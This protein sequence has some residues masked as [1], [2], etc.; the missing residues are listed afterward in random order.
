MR[1]VGTSVPVEGEG[2]RV[3]SIHPST[4]GDLVE[5]HAAGFNKET[6]KRGDLLRKL[7]ENGFMT[8]GCTN[9]VVMVRSKHDDTI[10]DL[11]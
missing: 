3:G 2:E 8:Q 11:M 1:G 6:G 10:S 5:N 4:N 7:S 9:S